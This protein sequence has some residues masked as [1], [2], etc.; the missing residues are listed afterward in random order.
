MDDNSKN[1]GQASD[2]LN[3]KKHQHDPLGAV[4][5]FEKMNK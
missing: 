3:V 2:D 4:F 5:Y 1:N